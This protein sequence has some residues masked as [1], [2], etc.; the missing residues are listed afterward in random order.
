MKVHVEPPTVIFTATSKSKHLRVCIA[1][2]F[3]FKKNYTLSR[4]PSWKS[5]LAW[6]FEPMDQDSK[7]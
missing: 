6:I 3:F 5:T 2:L 7:Q 1:F 4:G